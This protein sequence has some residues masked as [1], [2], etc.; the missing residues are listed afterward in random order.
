M[1]LIC[2]AACIEQIVIVISADL[3]SKE[4]SSTSKTQADLWCSAKIKINFSNPWFIKFIDMEKFAQQG[5]ASAALYDV[6]DLI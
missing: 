6:M 5:H 3:V 2:S 4:D 1:S